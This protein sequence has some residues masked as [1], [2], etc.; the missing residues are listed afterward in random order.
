[1]QMVDAMLK[2][3]AHPKRSLFHAEKPIQRYYLLAASE[4][5]FMKHTTDCGKSADR[6]IGGPCQRKPRLRDMIETAPG[7][8]PPFLHFDWMFALSCYWN[9]EVKIG[10]SP[11]KS[12]IGQKSQTAYAY[13]MIYW[14][15]GYY[16]HANQ[17]NFLVHIGN[18]PTTKLDWSGWLV[19]TF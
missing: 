15:N 14:C 5:I 12:L 19:L 16:R 3:P 13:S 7:W 1:M 10:H 17:K 6:P 11:I 2:S 4:C 18:Q 8:C 9:K